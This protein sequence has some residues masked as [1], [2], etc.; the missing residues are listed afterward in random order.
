MNIHQLLQQMTLEE[1]IGQLTQYPADF[2]SD[3]QGGCNRPLAC[4]WL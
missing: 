2:F 1:K 3:V 4:A